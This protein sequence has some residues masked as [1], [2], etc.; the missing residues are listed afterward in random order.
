MDLINALKKFALGPIFYQHELKEKRRIPRLECAI[1]AHAVIDDRDVLLIITDVSVKGIKVES[2]VRLAGGLDFPLTVRAGSGSLRSMG[3]TFDTLNVR[4]IQCRKKPLGS[5][6]LARLLFTD[7]ENRIRE[8]WVYY[9]FGLFGIDRPEQDQKREIIRDPYELDVLCRCGSR[10]EELG[11]ARDVGLGGLLLEFTREIEPGASIEMKIL[12]PYDS[13]QLSMKGTV[14]RT[15]FLKTTHRWL[16]AIRFT[17]MEERVYK[18]LGK[19]ILTLHKS[20]R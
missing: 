3:F 14:V 13:Q 7:H 18:A 19:L 5:K 8:S 9:L 16:L 12:S 15:E 17:E 2:P 10:K 20:P 4:V 1:Q 11:M 6:F